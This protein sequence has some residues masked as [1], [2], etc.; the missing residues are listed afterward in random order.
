MNS[1]NSSLR[2]LLTP[3]FVLFC[4]LA[5]IL[6]AAMFLKDPAAAASGG[7]YVSINPIG[8]SEPASHDSHQAARENMAI[9]ESQA[10]ANLEFFNSRFERY[11]KELTLEEE[12]ALGR[13]DLVTTRYQ[14]DALRDNLTTLQELT[15][16]WAAETEQITTKDVG[17]QI[18]ADRELLQNFDELDGEARM[19]ARDVKQT[20][21]QLQ[22]LADF[23]AMLEQQDKVPYEPSERFHQRLAAL[24]L[25]VTVAVFELR[26]SLAQLRHIHRSAVNLPMGEEPLMDAVYRLRRERRLNVGTDSGNESKDSDSSSSSDSHQL[27]VTTTTAIPMPSVPQLIEEPNIPEPP[28]PDPGSRS[29]KTLFDVSEFRQGTAV[30]TSYV[31]PPGPPEENSVAPYSTPF[32]RTIRV[33]LPT[34]NGAPQTRSVQNGNCS[35]ACRCGCQHNCRCSSRRCR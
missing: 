5:L 18:A 23:V 33:A 7:S 4:S 27:V 16:A 8:L 24:S 26:E 10:V 19:S 29:P 12:K 15:V 2:T 22:P 3:I 1:N 9:A 11:T 28:N 21:E 31:A 13:S 6:I 25:K 34:V 14:M 35:P 30:R 17:L 32:P 20:Q